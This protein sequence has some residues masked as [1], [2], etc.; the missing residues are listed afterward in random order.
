MSEQ[1]YQEHQDLMQELNEYADYKRE[2]C[3]ECNGDGWVE[4]MGD[5]GNG[6]WEV[7]ATRTC[8]ECIK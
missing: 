1:Q 7:I 5:C 2:N 8:Y 3:E 6:E 4:I